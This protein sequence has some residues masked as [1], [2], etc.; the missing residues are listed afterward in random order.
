MFCLTC[1]LSLNTA[2][3]TVGV[4]LLFLLAA[5]IISIVTGIQASEHLMVI[6]MSDYMKSHFGEFLLIFGG[7]TGT[8]IMVTIIPGVL[9]LTRLKKLYIHVIYAVILFF[10]FAMQ[11][12]LAMVIFTSIDFS[13]KAFETYCDSGEWSP[14][15]LGSMMQDVARTMAEVQKKA[16]CVEKCACMSVKTFLWSDYQLNELEGMYFTGTMNDALE[17]MSTD[18][19]INVWDQKVLDW[20]EDLEKKYMCSGLCSALSFYSFTDV[21]NGPPESACLEAIVDSELNEEIMYFGYLYLASGS[22]VFLAWY[23]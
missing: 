12:A 19:E 21:T 2:Y 8:V 4:S 10:P 23:A 14:D 20:I 5:G 13:A 16:L 9:I 11:I 15:R 1:C 22:L 6:L 18:P 3:I 17:C 7:T